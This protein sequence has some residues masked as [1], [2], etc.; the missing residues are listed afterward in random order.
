[1]LSVAVV[2]CCRSPVL[3]VMLDEDD[4]NMR[5]DEGKPVRNIKHGSLR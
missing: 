5:T 1:M 2:L 4:D 3:L